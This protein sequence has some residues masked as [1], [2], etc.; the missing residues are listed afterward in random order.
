MYTPAVGSNF[1][2][3]VIFASCVRYAY[4]WLCVLIKDT[5]RRLALQL[6]WSH[7]GQQG[8]FCQCVRGNYK[9]RF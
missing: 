9:T 1:V 2:S 6:Q 4:Y 5:D 7:Q 8:D 3:Q